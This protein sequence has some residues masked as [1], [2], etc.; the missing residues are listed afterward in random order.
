MLT[1]FAMHQEKAQAFECLI[2]LGHDG[3]VLDWGNDAQRVFGWTDQEAIGRRLGE[4]LVP[5]S[6]FAVFE[7]APESTVTGLRR[8]APRRPQLG[9]AVLYLVSG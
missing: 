7:R 5:A 6:T 4:L 3:V 9:L 1:T 2:T 8:A